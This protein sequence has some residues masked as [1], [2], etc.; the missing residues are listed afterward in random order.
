[1]GFEPM[2]DQASRPGSTCI[3]AATRLFSSPAAVKKRTVTVFLIDLN[4]RNGKDSKRP[5]V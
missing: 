3:S 5:S 4:Y 2:S 1:M